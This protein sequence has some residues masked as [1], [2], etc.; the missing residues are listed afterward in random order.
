MSIELPSVVLT[1]QQVEQYHTDGYLVLE[2]LVSAAVCDVLKDRMSSL[3]STFDPSEYRSI[4]TTNEQSRHTDQYFMDSAGKISFFFEEEAFD[5]QGELK[6][7]LDLSINKVGHG[8]HSQDDVFRDFSLAAVWGSML[9]QLG[10]RE[11]RAAQSMYIFKQPGIGGEV[12]CHQDSTF[13]YTN[14]MSVIG[15]WFAIE[16]ATLENGCL[17]GIPKGHTAG[18]LKRF[19]RDA[20]GSIETKMVAL[21]EHQWQADELVSLP[22]PKGS[23]VLLNGEFPH[24]SYANRSTKSRHAYAVHAV[25]KT[26]DYPDVNW[27]QPNVGNDFPAFQKMA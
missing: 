10:M 4:F 2:S 7:S 22:V 12:N 15:L 20:A 27:L 9:R 11:P 21:K 5:E 17:W 14:P 19:E 16:D 6:Q 1:K 25:D 26:C 8:L 24:L 23:L 18:L 13:L 3:L